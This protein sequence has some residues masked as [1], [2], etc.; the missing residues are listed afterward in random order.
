M[1]VLD[2]RFFALTHKRG[3]GKLFVIIHAEDLLFA[4]QSQDRQLDL[5]FLEFNLSKETSHSSIGTFNT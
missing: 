1:A 2:I 3:V 5:G 4:M